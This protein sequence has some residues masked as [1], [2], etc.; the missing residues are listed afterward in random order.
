MSQAGHA[1]RGASV[2]RDL[3]GVLL[4]VCCAAGGLVGLRQGM[5]AVPTDAVSPH[6]WTA[7]T[8]VMQRVAIGVAVGVAI[9]ALVATVLCAAGGYCWAAIRRS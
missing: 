4:A 5:L 2:R 1:G 3:S 8:D 7:L 9:G 6:V